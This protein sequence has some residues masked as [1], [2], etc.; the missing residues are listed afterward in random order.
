MADV[1]GGNIEAGRKIF[2]HN[3]SACASCHRIGKQGGNVGP[4]LTTIGAIRESRD[5]LEAVVLPS[6]SFA[7]GFRPYLIVT[8]DGKTLT[9]V[10]TRESTEAITLR[11]ATLAEIHIPRAEIDEL[12]ESPT[13]IMPQG[14]ET[15]LSETELRDLLAYLKSLK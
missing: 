15:R 12:R 14:L 6:S 11:T 2:F 9:G 10:M 1:A 13:S 4:D 5:L 8:T 7:R 3:K